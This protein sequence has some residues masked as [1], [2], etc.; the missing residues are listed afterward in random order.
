MQD[1]RRQGPPD[2][3]RRAGLRRRHQRL[4]RRPTARTQPPATVNDVIAVTAFIGSIFGAGGGGEASNADLL[5][6]LQQRARPGAR[7][8]GLGRRHAGRRPGG[9]DHHPQPLR[10]RPAD[11]RQGHAARWSSTRARS[12]RSTP[13]AAAGPAAGERGR[14]RR[15]GARR[16]RTSWWSR[17]P[18]GHRQHA[19]GDGP[20]A[21][22]LLPRDRPADPPARPGHQGPGRGRARPRHVHPH[23]PDEELR[24][25]PHLGQPRRPRRVRRAA[26]QPRR[27]DARPGRPTHYL[28]KGKCRPFDDFDAGTARRHSRSATR[29]SVHGPVIGTAT[30]D[31]K[32]YALTRQRSTFGRDGLNLAALKDMTEGKATTPQ[33]LLP[34]RPTSSA[35]R[36]TGPTPPAS[37]TA[38]FSS[39]LPAGARAA[40]STAGSRRS[41]PA[42]TSGSGFLR[43]EPAPARRRAARTACCSTGTTSR[44]RASCTATTR[45]YGSVHRVELFDKFPK[46][47]QA[48]RRGERHEPRGDRGRPL[49]GLAGGEPGAARRAGAE[50]PRR[51]GR[52]TCSTT[53]SG[54]TRPRLDAD[55]DG[56]YDD[57]GPA[58]MDAAWQPDRRGGHAAGARAT[59]STTWTTS[60][61]SAACPGES[62]VDKDLRTLLGAQRARQVQPALLRQR[63]AGRLPRLAV[64]GCPPGRRRPRGAVRAAR[65]DAVAQDGGADRRSRRA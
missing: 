34:K 6:K 39:G 52:A 3:E 38:F 49:A 22:L 56:L 8:Q 20:A 60:A 29:P 13:A 27:L 59:C 15:R 46:R 16:R 63:L 45:P 36:S 48:R 24:V 50:R 4:L 28:F 17:R 42:S 26:L 41:A 31:G 5:A 1:L 11:R 47:R 51:A 54:A 10:L 62:Y 44:R 43:A 57:A 40:A 19:G 25:E 30:V 64:G 2:P 21:R 37:D 61:A 23:R 14:R 35:S 32:P 53:G 65:P 33:Q 58:I 7:P 12:W 55:I 18:L 9:A